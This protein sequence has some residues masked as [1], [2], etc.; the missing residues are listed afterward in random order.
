MHTF[1]ADGR[2]ARC[3]YPECPIWVDTQS[4][5]PVNSVKVLAQNIPIQGQRSWYACEHHIREVK[6]AQPDVQLDFHKK[7]SS[8]GKHQAEQLT[9]LLG[10]M[11][12]KPLEVTEQA[13]EAGIIRWTKY[14]T[15]K[16]ED[17]NGAKLEVALLNALARLGIPT[18]FAGS[19]ACG[20]NETPVY[21][22]VALGFFNIQV[23]TTVLISCKN[24]TH[25]PNLGEI[26]RLSDEVH[27]V[28]Q[29]LSGW[30]VFGTLTLTTE[31]TADEFGYRNDIRIWKQPHIRAILN[32][33]AKEQ[34]DRLVWTHPNH[35]NVTSEALWR[36]LYDAFSSSQGS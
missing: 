29:L 5:E 16:Q 35:W 24:S 22:L 19:G 28:K 1:N 21:D 3:A 9:R 13:I 18:F 36:S 23:P 10:H 11:Y 7:T 2:W 26:G 25:Q 30:L 20:G 32:A 12:R 33:Q 15:E 14:L 17:G 27:K 6:D 8:D 4:S 34:V 31:P